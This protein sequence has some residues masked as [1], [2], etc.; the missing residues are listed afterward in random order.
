M[1][2]GLSMIGPTLL[3]FGT[4]EQKQLGIEYMGEARAMFDQLV[5]G[6][7]PN[8]TKDLDRVPQTWLR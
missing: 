1:G 6:S 5:A 8:R 7:H 4:P 2:M 3:E